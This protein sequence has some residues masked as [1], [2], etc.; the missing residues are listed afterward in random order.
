MALGKYGEKMVDAVQ[1]AAA[2]SP[3]ASSK[4][5]ETYNW[6]GRQRAQFDA[7]MD[8]Q[9]KAT[10]TDKVQ[11]GFKDV[12]DMMNPLQHLPI[13]KNIY[14]AVT[15][16][17]DMKPA[18]KTVGDAIY[19]GPVG[20][21]SSVFDNIFKDASGKD[22]ISTAANWLGLGDD[23]APA[24]QTASAAANTNTMVAAN[25]A[26]TTPVPA[27]EAAANAAAPAAAAQTSAP[28]P[29]P[30]K[31]MMLALASS[32]TTPA[33]SVAVNSATAANSPPPSSPLFDKLQRGNLPQ[34]QVTGGTQAKF[35]NPTA[36]QFAGVTPAS[37]K[38]SK[39]IAN[40][41]ASIALQ[42]SMQTNELTQN[43]VQSSNSAISSSMAQ[44]N[45]KMDTVQNPQ[46]EFS[47]KMLAA[48]DRYEAV[49][50][51]GGGD[52]APTVSQGL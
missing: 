40:S 10:G 24:T 19:G 48:M 21:V 29:A 39:D 20:A 28:N 14:Q 6:S 34:A 51:M 44:A 22:M 17:D 38:P 46:S 36:K 5:T 7:D 4:I 42:A 16:D 27:T 8:A 12:L 31:P 9:A 43:A 26:A 32:P 52:A 11:L 2:A 33:P 18:V 41:P 45:A 3:L 35:F 15:G 47:Q 25:T 1:T 37:F 23:A 30:A 49:K 13:I 50:K